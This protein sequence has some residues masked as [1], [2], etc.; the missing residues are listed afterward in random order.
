MPDAP[1]NLAEDTTQRTSA[2]N[3]LTW[4]DGTN[5]GGLPILDYRISMRV[6]GG[7]YAVYASGVTT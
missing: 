6:E 1:I 4:S 5:N 2:T 3:G 7:V